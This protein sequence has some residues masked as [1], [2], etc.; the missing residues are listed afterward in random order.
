[1]SS[2]QLSVRDHQQ[3]N[4]VSILLT[5]VFIQHVVLHALMCLLV[6]LLFAVTS[7]LQYALEH[8]YSLCPIYCFGEVDLYHNLQVVRLC[9]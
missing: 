4:R 1:M 8:G 2:M 5:Q 7:T 3:Y 6:S 9:A